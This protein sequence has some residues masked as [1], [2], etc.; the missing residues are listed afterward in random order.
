MWVQPE[1]TQ[2]WRPAVCCSQIAARPPPRHGAGGHPGREGRSPQPVCSAAAGSGKTTLLL[3]ACRCSPASLCTL[4]GEPVL[5]L[6][7][8]K[9]LQVE[10]SRALADAAPA[11]ACGTSHGLCT[12]HLNVDCVGGAKPR[13]HC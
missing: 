13:V 12:E 7:Y 2:T 9:L 4:R 10:I 5:V 1:A 8:N 11:C 6:T 3:H